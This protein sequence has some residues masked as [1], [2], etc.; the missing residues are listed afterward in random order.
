MFLAG[1]LAP[2][3]TIWTNCSRA[4]T[5]NFEVLVAGGKF[6]RVE[7]AIAY[8]YGYFIEYSTGL[9]IT[10][11]DS[12]LIISQ[13]DRTHVR[14]MTVTRDMALKSY[15]VTNVGTEFIIGK[16]RYALNTLLPEES[17]YLIEM[18]RMLLDYLGINHIDTS[19]AKFRLPPGR[20]SILPGI[21]NT[22]LVDSTYNATL[23]GTKSILAM[24]NRY[25]APIKWAVI[26]DM[27]ELGREEREEHERLADFIATTALAKIIL[28][29]PRVLAYTYPV[30]RLRSKHP[31]RIAKFLYPREVLDYL[32]AEI[33]GGET[34]LFKGARFLE[35]VI[36]RLL[37]NTK[38]ADKLCRRESI[39]H[40]RRKQW[41]L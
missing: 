9:V 20:S 27:L 24:Y 17:F 18:T 25:P 35:G 41:G 13:Q 23:E 14:I 40:I 37:V 5:L 10:N 26:G 1:L 32:I 12:P 30:L 7:E 38:D 11:G 22:T 4:H 31:D 33:R 21:K 19:F 36:E 6:A 8:E 2:E 15:Q 39:W 34:I 3:V 29:G 28:M 16:M